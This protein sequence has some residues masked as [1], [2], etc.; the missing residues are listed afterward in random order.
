MQFHRRRIFFNPM[1][2]LRILILFA[3]LFQFTNFVDAGESYPIPPLRRNGS[4]QIEGTCMAEA[5]AGSFEHGLSRRGFQAKVSILYLHQFL[6]KDSN[7]DVLLKKAV[8]MNPESKKIFDGVGAIIP[9]YMLP[10]DHEGVSIFDSALSF[11]SSPGKWVFPSIDRLALISEDFHGEQINFRSEFFG[12]RKGFRNS[13]TFDQFMDHVKNNEMLTIDVH[14]KLFDFFDHFNGTMTVPYKWDLFDS[15]EIDHELAVVGYDDQL[16]GIIVRNS[17]NTKELLADFSAKL[18]RL[19][20][21]KSKIVLSTFKSKLGHPELP[22]YY[23]I[24]YEYIRDLANYGESGYRI[25]NANLDNFMMQYRLLE[26]KYQVIKALYT[27]DHDNLDFV[28]NE[29]KDQLRI[30]KSN[31]VTEEVRQK[32]MGIVV[33]II[34]KQKKTTSNFLSYALIPVVEGK[35]QDLIQDFYRGSL[36]NYYCGRYQNSADAYRNFW[37]IEG[38]DATLS[39]DQFL[40]HVRKISGQFDNNDYWLKFLDFL[41]ERI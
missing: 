9:E 29:L 5:T 11:M 16:Q 15:A 37:P 27:C 38:R 39:D 8:Q 1:W 3:A 7:P 12:F 13:S 24:P 31:Q 19:T 33:Q 22:G 4:R 36:A 40:E 2:R 23:L 10:E 28:L 35:S 41:I 20:N 21:G 32:A 18:G 30:S 14:G 6:Y 26:P 17:W 34:E 25:L